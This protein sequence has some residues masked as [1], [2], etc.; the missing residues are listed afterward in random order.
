MS[1]A[2]NKYLG[3]KREAPNHRAPSSNIS[4]SNP[5]NLNEELPI[6]KQHQE[7][8]N[9]I[10]SNQIVIICGS[11][12]CGKTTQIPQLIYNHSIQ[13]NKEPSIIITQPRRLAATTISRRLCKE[14]NFSLGKEIGFQVGMNLNYSKQTKIVLK[15]TGIF[16][17][18]LINNKEKVA[19]TY[20]HIILDEI[21]ERD[22]NIDLVLIFIKDLIKLNKNIKII[23]M[24]ATISS[25][26]FSSYFKDVTINNKPPP[27]I[28]IDVPRYKITYYYLN[29]IISKINEIKRKGGNDQFHLNRSMHFDVGNAYLDEGIFPIA[30]DII[31]ICDKDERI[32]KRN[33]CILVFLPGIGEILSFK[34]YLENNLELPN[35]FEIFI[36]HSNIPQDEQDKVMKPTDKRKVILATNIA[37]SSL[38][39]PNT[40]Y[41]IDFCLLKEVYYN[42]MANNESLNLVW[43]SKANCMQRSGRTGRLRD[44]TV[45]RLVTDELYKLLPDYPS[46]EIKRM[47]LEK[48]VLKVKIYY[49]F[50]PKDILS[51]AIQPPELQT[52]DDTITYLQNF[53]AL[54]LGDTTNPTGELTEWGRVYAK[55]PIDIRYA[56][57]I[58]LCYAFNM[59][60][61]GIV[62]AAL[63]SQEKKIF[64]TYGEGRFDIFEQKKCYAN[65]S[66]C[67]MI[68]AY[69]AFKEW[70]KKF[71]YKFV[72]DEFDTK[73][74]FYKS[75]SMICK[76]ETKWCKERLLDSKVLKEILR[77]VSDIKKRLNK[78]NLYNSSINNNGKKILT[79]IDFCKG[80]E[81]IEIFKFILAG[82]FY[83]NIF[84]PS[85]KQEK[86]IKNKRNNNNESSQ[87]Q[88]D[89]IVEVINIPQ[90]Y[91][92]KLIQYLKTL[93]DSEDD[94][95][96]NNG[97]SSHESFDD[98]LRL[99]FTTVEATR[100][101][102]FVMSNGLYNNKF[103]E[104]LSKKINYYGTRMKISFLYEPEF[105]TII[106]PRQIDADNDSSNLV[107][108]ESNTE[109]M[110]ITRYVT[111]QIYERKNRYCPHF[112]S[113]LP[114]LPLFDVLAIL[115]FA[116]NVTFHQNE[117]MNQY[118]KFSISTS[119]YGKEIHFTYLFSSVDLMKINEI[120][121]ILNYLFKLKIGVYRELESIQSNGDDDNETQNTNQQDED[122]YSNKLML[123]EEIVNAYCELSENLNQKVK[124]LLHKKRFKVIIREEWI[125]LFNRFYPQQRN[126]LAQNQ[127]QHIEPNKYI[128]SYNISPNISNSKYY[129]EKEVDMLPLLKPLGFASDYSYW[130]DEGMNELQRERDLYNK[131]KE[132][133]KSS[134]EENERIMYA[135]DGD[136]YCGRCDSFI[137]SMKSF[138]QEKSCGNAANT[139]FVIGGW[140][141]MNLKLCELN[142]DIVNEDKFVEIN[143]KYHFQP[144]KYV[145]CSSGRH[146]VGFY[147]EESRK[148]Y[149]TTYSELKIKFPMQSIKSFTQELWKDDFK[150]YK[151]L[152]KRDLEERRKKLEQGISCMLCNEL[153]YDAKEFM[154][155]KKSTHHKARYEDLCNEIF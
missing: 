23:L 92:R 89:K 44:G 115:I 80:S 143:K 38:T 154:N 28:E 17:E 10:T 91:H 118:E 54:T 6:F 82:T 153:F 148:Y 105:R 129:N 77:V 51:K 94:K 95:N 102:V 145:C 97:I 106:N 15:T 67:D 18:E 139:L 117:A 45:F 4:L 34:D 134:L 83:T 30:K 122:E 140:V 85:Y 98:V 116:P 136:V 121:S 101:F 87:Y 12:G 137:C 135:E 131:L 112:V 20:T 40:D 8:I 29:E 146:I 69:N 41:V 78:D 11:T 93:Y 66:D 16:L 150:K 144:D 103:I 58:M 81:K 49:Q 142:D 25:R 13:H 1:A 55:L 43:A 114:T 37:E 35:D 141:T 132:L 56:R 65:G 33:S 100:K 138:S 79:Y 62:V 149:A 90:K 96:E 19:T 50:D 24:S 74:K 124:S 14:M 53:G 73:M 5:Y 2:N 47:S 109:R 48:V 59:I 76:E 111:D 110:A 113:K 147:M 71:G 120:R 155:H 107:L 68:T 75:S 7:I 26:Q 46:P 36:L 72:E 152:L 39:I 127:Q 108:I 119:G 22:I 123:Y 126:L 9:A 151:E 104:A 3:Y 42:Q 31:S 70:E 99:I 88:H 32:N 125:E 52:V 86:N 130:T 27:I 60:E 64:R 128:Y 63:L 133:V 21:H 61:A 57:L 84:A